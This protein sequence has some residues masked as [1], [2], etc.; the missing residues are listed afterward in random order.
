VRA[1]LVC[2]LAL[3]VLAA[4]VGSAAAFGDCAQPNYLEYFHENIAPEPC[5]EIASFPVVTAS[6]RSLL[7][8]IRLRDTPHGD[9][10]VWVAH[11]ESLAVALGPA[12]DAIGGVRLPP[13]ITVLL[14]QGERFIERFQAHAVT[15]GLV[16]FDDG[17][18]GTVETE[19][20]V[21]FYKLDRA[22]PVEEFMVAVA[23]EVFH[24]AQHVTWPDAYAG[25]SPHWWR[26]GSAEYFTHLVA[27]GMRLRDGW[28]A[29]FDDASLGQSLL[30]MRYENVVFFLWLADR[31]GPEA[32][33]AF[34]SG[35]TAGDQLATLRALVPLADWRAFVEAYIDGT[36]HR[37]SGGAIPPPSQFTGSPVF[38]G[39]ETL[40]MN[41]SDYVVRR[42]ELTFAEEKLFDLSLAV[43][44]GAP[45][46]AMKPADSEAGWAPPPA[47]V[48]TC[49]EEKDFLA[50]ALSTDS[51]GA[52]TLTVGS[53]AD[54]T[55]GACCLV[56]AW[57]PTQETLDGFAAF[58]MQVGA[59]PIAAQGGS[60]SCGYT[61]G[62]WV[63][64]FG[65]DGAGRLEFEGNT[66][67]CTVSG[68]GGAIR[69]DEV[70]NGT[71]GFD[72]E[73]AG[74]GAGM[75]HYTENT[76]GWEIT[77]H[78]GPVTQSHGG[79]DAGPSTSSNGFAFTCERDDLTIQGLYGISH[80][81]TTYLRFAE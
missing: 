17:H 81:E 61:S 15:E 40:A 28:I 10:A 76:L 73:V 31:G 29:A 26:E 45:V 11:A 16:A 25:A 32:V 57:S 19:C 70:R 80:K 18:G 37:P 22:V 12:I 24:C 53:D 14:T 58:G 38:D 30:E 7:R 5:D 59:G 47:Q 79:A 49:K 65:E 51:A 66:N 9:D 52:A 54:R 63:L 39:P 78:I 13:E 36:I 60:L 23:H 41:A 77:M 33:G 74:E 35:M 43:E 50:Y 56:G 64:E 48:N 6:G 21:P 67:S 1:I 44:S 75:A 2:R 62:G 27:P 20:A 34:L 4:S 69:Y 8:V 71:I 46:V 42:W 72:W 68:G 55:G 3:V